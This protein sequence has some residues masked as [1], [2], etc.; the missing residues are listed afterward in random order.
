LKEA[1]RHAKEGNAEAVAAAGRKLEKISQLALRHRALAIELEALQRGDEV[2]EAG[3][4]VGGA[5]LLPSRDMSGARERGRRARQE[6]L[7]FLKSRGVILR[8]EKGDAIYKKTSGE[9]VGVSYA[10][11][12]QPNK[13]FM[14]LP[15][16][17]YMDAIL[18]CESER[19]VNR[20]VLDRMFLAKYG[21]SLSRSNGQFKI[22]VV[23]RGDG[24]FSMKVRG[25]GRW[26][27]E[28]WEI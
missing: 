27:C 22:N 8:P 17:G 7:S 18:L 26:R 25:P 13:W 28:S 21:A 6:F 24:E 19:G 15:T 3:Q 2:P 20:L 14:G 5:V 10:S 16:R 23:R 1:E 4:D 11:E 12:R 9:N